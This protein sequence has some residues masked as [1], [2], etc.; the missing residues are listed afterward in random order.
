MTAKLY[1]NDDSCQ[2]C[3][4]FDFVEIKHKNLEE[5]GY[6]RNE[7]SAAFSHVL[8]SKYPSCIHFLEKNS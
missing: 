4:Y 1:K 5:F 3:V 8:M 6:C 2:D 7:D